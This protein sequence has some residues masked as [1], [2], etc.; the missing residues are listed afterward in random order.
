MT[1][2][3]LSLP[4]HRQ[5]CDELLELHGWDNSA[6]SLGVTKYHYHGDQRVAMRKAGVVYFN[7]T[8]HLGST[9]STTD[10]TG[11]VVAEAR[12][13]PYGEEHWTNGSAK[14]DFTFTGQRNEA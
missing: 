13:P 1:R 10:M 8:D 14:R 2:L 4:K 12:Y 6:P 11:R 9:S 7:H 5:P 3:V